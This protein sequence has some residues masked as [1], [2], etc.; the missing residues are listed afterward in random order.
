[1]LLAALCLTPRARAT[2]AFEI[3]VYDG[4]ANEPWQPGLELHLNHIASG[5]KEPSAPEI[6]PHRQTHMTLEPSLGILPWWE[7]G[8]YLQTAIVPDSGFEWAGAKLRSKFVTPPKWHEHVRLGVNLEVS[9][10]PHRFERDRWGTEARP[11]AA[12]ESERFLFVINPIVATPLGG[13]GFRDGPELEPAAK[14][15]VKIAEIVGLG[16]EYYAG[17]GP[18][19]S[20]FAP[21]REQEH[22]L[23]EVADLLAIDALELNLGV[24]EGLT[25]ASN[26]LVIK[27]IVGYVFDTPAQ[28]SAARSAWRR[29]PVLRARSLLF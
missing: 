16:F 24:G 4:T 5:L 27:M 20:G 17:L 14:A 12:W 26:P 1:L 10:V 3:Q 25:E 9:L 2:D 19:A 28:P 7:L 23:Y 18:I 21:W 15:A 29:A 13:D 6:A 22:Y 11:I 8:A